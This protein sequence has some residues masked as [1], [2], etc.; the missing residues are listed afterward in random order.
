MDY[1][2]DGMLDLIVGERYGYIHYYRRTSESP[3]TL[4]KE[5]DI[6]CASIRIDVGNNSAPVCVDWNE[7]GKRD[8]LVGNESAGNIRLYI[9]DSADDDPVYNTYSLIQSS[10]TSIIHYRNCPQVYD[11]NM[12]GKKDILVGISNG[13]IRYYENT[14]TNDAPVFS[15]S[16]FIIST[17]SSGARFWV[18]DWNEDGLP[19]V[20]ASNFNGYIRVYIQLFQSIEGEE[21]PATRKL[22]VSRNPFAG[23]VVING[24]GFSNGTISIYDLLGRVVLSEPFTGSLEWNASGASAGYYFA[25]VRD[26]QGSAVINLLKL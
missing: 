6:V 10:G 16:E 2:N 7:D 4:T 24:N 21:T 25:E 26:A 11:M 3:I 14:G 17:G 15:G 12:D 20:L 9:N 19:D 1:D 13:Q 23:S 18:N 8:L 5:A 22:A